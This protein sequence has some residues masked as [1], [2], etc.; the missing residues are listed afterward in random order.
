M[1][2]KANTY[3]VLTRDGVN[4]NKHR[5]IV[6]EILGKPLPP[7]A[8]IHHLNGIKHD[9]RPMNLVVC[10]DRRYH[11]LLHRRTEALEVTGNADSLK[12]QFCKQWDT[13]EN[14]VKIR[15][16]GRASKHYHR[17]CENDYQRKKRNA[18]T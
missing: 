11:Y 16:A 2:Q 13:P 14:I 17:A 3:R 10:P 6:E 1:T 18:K 7:R 9:N 12:C 8:E 15:Y 4:R 5:V